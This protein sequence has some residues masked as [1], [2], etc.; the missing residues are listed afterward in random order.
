[1]ILGMQ[2]SSLEKIEKLLASKDQLGSS[3]QLSDVKELNKNNITYA[4]LE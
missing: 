1:M 3:P 4:E 2:K